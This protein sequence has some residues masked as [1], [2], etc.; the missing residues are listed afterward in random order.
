MASIYDDIRATLETKLNS[1]VGLPY[2]KPEN[3]SYTPGTDPYI[4]TLLVPTIRRP[5][6]RGENPQ[7]FYK[8]IFRVF[9]HIKVGTAV[10][11]A[12]DMADLILD[13]MDATTDISWTNPTTSEVTTLS[14][15][16]AE[17][18]QGIPENKHYY[19]PVNIGWYLYN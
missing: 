17:R 7:M 6:H 8:G 19:V 14:I 18:E 10:G 12:D 15:E 16:Y 2:I 3:V 9:C 11:E 1:V 4:E 13:A 5:A